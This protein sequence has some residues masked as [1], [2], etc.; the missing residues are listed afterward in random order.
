MGVRPNKIIYAN[1]C[2]TKSYIK[3]AETVGVD[4][5]TFDNEQELYKVAQLYPAAHMVLRIKVDDSH[6]VC[7]F[8]AK[9]GADLIKASHLLELAKHLNI[10]IVGV[11]FHVGM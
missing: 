3:H 8:S 7:Q 5:M 9:F 1:P 6:A 4:L 11:S 2:K 10:N